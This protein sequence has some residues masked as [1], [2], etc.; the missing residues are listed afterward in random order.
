MAG[1]TVE[2]RKFMV[3][4][5]FPLSK[6]SKCSMGSVVSTVVQQNFNGMA[7]MLYSLYNYVVVVTCIRWGAFVY[8]SAYVE[9]RGQLEES[10]LSCQLKQ[11]SLVMSL[12][13]SLAI[14][15]A[16]GQFSCLCPSS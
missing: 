10:V 12:Y 8:H 1:R 14:T 9:V 15:G 7:P 6:V 11:P 13:P 3:R 4:I 5:K 16:S 2:G